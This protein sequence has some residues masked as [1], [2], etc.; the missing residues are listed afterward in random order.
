MKAHK[1]LLVVDDQAEIRLLVRLTF[2]GQPFGVREA[3]DGEA[4]LAA[5]RAAPVDV[6]VLDI[7]MPQLD[8]FEVCRRIKANPEWAGIR[9]ILL[10]AADQASER[11]RGIEAG[12]DWYMP[13]P[14][15]PSELIKVV[16]RLLAPA[17]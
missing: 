2:S 7:M 14:F 13:K 5:L 6:V 15:S 11:V 4:A 16:D 12:A 9:V 1:Q 17:G 10:T 3:S 8:G